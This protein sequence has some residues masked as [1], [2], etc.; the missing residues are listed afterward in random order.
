MKD[1]DIPKLK[2]NQNIV[3]G[4]NQARRAIEN[5]ETQL[6]LLA[7]DAEFRIVAEVRE[8]CE[9]CNCKVETY[10]SKLELGKDAGINVG[11]SIVCVLK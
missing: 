11:A 9:K 2:N 8:M 4:M 6:A 7:A 5:G 10:P 3:I 1:D